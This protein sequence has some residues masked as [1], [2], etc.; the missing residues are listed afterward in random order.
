MT[1]GEII[2]ELILIA[3]VS[4]EQEYQDQ[5]YFLPL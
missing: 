3:E 4:F 5:I 2:E 1:T